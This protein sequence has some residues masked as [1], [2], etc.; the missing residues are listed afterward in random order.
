MNYF[1]KLNILERT[2]V[3]KE[4]EIQN[5]S[6]KNQKSEDNKHFHQLLIGMLITIFG[7]ASYKIFAHGNKFNVP[8]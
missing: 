4:L 3:E 6:E 8:H 5:E 2:R 1:N 7:V